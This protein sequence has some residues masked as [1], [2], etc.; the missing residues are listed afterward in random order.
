[1]II[2]LP[3][4]TMDILTAVFISRSLVLDVNSMDI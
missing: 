4:I 3:H 1:M 2:G